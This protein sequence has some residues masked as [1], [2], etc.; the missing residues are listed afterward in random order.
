MPSFATGL[1]LATALASSPGEPAP[2][3]PGPA[4]ASTAPVLTAEECAVW[5]RELSFAASV[6][7]HDAAAFAEHVAADAVFGVNGPRVQRGRQAVVDGWA[8][9]VRGEGMR[10]EWYPQHVTA[11]GDLAWS[12]GPALVEQ[13]EG[14]RPRYLLSAYQSVWRRGADGVWHVL[15]DGG[16]APREASDAQAQAFRAARPGGCPGAAP[17]A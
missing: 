10:L 7:A 9:I 8:R 12:T 6:A 3:A 14:R 1:V 16:T 13:L 17:A 2:P 11:V 15:F 5:R 4:S